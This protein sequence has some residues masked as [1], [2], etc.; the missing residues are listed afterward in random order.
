MKSWLDRNAKAIQAGSALATALVAVAALI[1]IKVQI[2][3]SAQLQREQSARD[4][5][6]EFLSLSIAQPRFAH[7]DMCAIAGT[8]DEAAYD[9]YLT[10]LLYT[11]EQV[12]A[13]QPDWETTM[14]AHLA[15]H[16]EALCSDADWSNE[17]P[18]VRALVNRYRAAE[19]KSFVSKCPEAGGLP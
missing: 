17:A 2:D 13:A 11:G 14:T 6:R 18:Q 1:G 5:Y 4:I 16:R 19:C 15:P 8:P 12:L 3:A 10:F 7:P 9:H